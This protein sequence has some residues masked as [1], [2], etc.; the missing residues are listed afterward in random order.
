MTD[1][2]DVHAARY[3][4]FYEITGLF[5]CR[6]RD[7]HYIISIDTTLNICKLQVVYLNTHSVSDAPGF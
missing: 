5:N 7:A 1:N 3:R 4:L 2:A 6:T